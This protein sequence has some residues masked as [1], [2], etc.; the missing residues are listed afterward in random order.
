MNMQQK[1]IIDP[2]LTEMK[3]Q[4]ANLQQSRNVLRGIINDRFHDMDLAWWKKRG[5]DIHT[6]RPEPGA[7]APETTDGA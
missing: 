7:P 4:M 5:I 1:K 3:G 6:E 2:A